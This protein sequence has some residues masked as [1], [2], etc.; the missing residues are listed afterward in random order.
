MFTWLTSLGSWVANPAILATGALLVAAP[1][2]IHLLN[3]RRFKI[4][5]W[6]AMDFLLEADRRNRRRVRLENLLVLLLRCLAVF[7][8]GLLLARPFDSSG[9]LAKL[10][11]TQKIEHILIVDDSVSMQARTGNESAM[12]EAHRRISDLVRSLTAGKTDQTITVV[13]ASRPTENLFQGSRLGAENV[14]DIVG[15]LERIEATDLDCSLATA[16]DEVE[17]VTA[18][19]PQTTNRI[20]YVV[21]D[22]RRR[23]WNP[24]ASPGNDAP[25]SAE[26]GTE[27]KSP[28]EELAIA[29]LRKL[30]KVV[31]SCYIIDVGNGDDSN[32]TIES[33]KS[34]QTLVAGVD[35]RFEV[36]IKNQGSKSIEGIKVKF[37]PEGSLGVTRELDVLGAGE[38]E[39]VSFSHSFPAPSE[40]DLEERR[41][42]PPSRVRVEVAADQGPADDRLAADSVSYFAARLSPGIPVLIVDGDPAAGF[43]KAESFYLKRA[44]SPPGKLSSGIVTDVVTEAELEGVDL[45]QYRV[46]FLCN[47]YRFSNDKSLDALTEWA[48]AG[49]A[50]VLL[51]GDQTD[52]SWFNGHLFGEGDKAGTGLSPARLVRIDGVES[53]DDATLDSWSNIKID[54]PTHPLLAAFA[55]QQN[56]I[57]SNVKVFRWWKVEPSAAAGSA[58][59]I[60]LSDPEESHL[61]IEKPFGKGRSFLF[62]GPADSDWSNWP[63]DPSFILLFQDLVRYASPGDS[64]QGKLSVGQTVKETVDIAQY[65]VNAVVATPH[66]G[67]QNVSLKQPA[68][69][70]AGSKWLLEFA[71][72]QRAGFYEATVQPRATT[73]AGARQV[74]FAANVTPEDGSLVRVEP[75][76]L[77]RA[78]SDTNIKVLSTGSSGIDGYRAQTE[79]WRY[80]LWGLVVVLLGEQLLA[81]VFGWG[82]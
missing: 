25:T 4:V 29:S 37:T 21:T 64:S 65:D 75:E 11:G 1:I 20:V 36:A 14:N 66:R 41:E 3:R 15:E 69:P 28:A 81:W 12:D 23:D 6:A 53:P 19:Q 38:S 55:G 59:L 34:E 2:I 62:A 50:V 79:I 76:T 42:L 47:V 9:L 51:P 61:L 45:K 30:S 57:L 74:L 68:D 46:V 48:T 40:S 13:R 7:L 26:A 24:N 73:T 43:G 82:R 10:T 54:I 60:K 63:S 80:I 49:G 33:V 67:K 18:G 39:V 72:T 35:S 56:P 52:E 8:L 27:T 22:L 58:T 44:L 70:A 31:K 16:I 77:Q 17:R 5:D 32:L 78:V 71:D